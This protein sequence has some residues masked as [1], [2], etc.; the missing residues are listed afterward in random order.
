MKRV[1]LDAEAHLISL[2]PIPLRPGAELLDVREREDSD[3]ISS[4]VIGSRGWVGL[5]GGS[6]S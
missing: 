1:G 5:G 4:S 6:S 2:Y 3:R